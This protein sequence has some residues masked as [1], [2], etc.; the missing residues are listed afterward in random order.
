MPADIPGNRPLIDELQSE[1]EER[2]VTVFVGA[3]ASAPIW[4]LWS[5]LRTTVA[6]HAVNAGLATE[7]D[8]SAWEVI[9]DPEISMQM[10]R[11]T[12]GVEGFVSVLRNI[13][14]RPQPD[15]GRT[16]TP[17]HELI[18]TRNL[19]A[20]VT[21]NYDPGLLDAKL[22]L[23]QDVN[24]TG[25]TNSAD[26][27]ALSLW[28]SGDIYEEDSLP[29]LHLHGAVDRPSTI[30]IS[31]DDYRALYSRPIVQSLLEKLWQQERLLFLGYSFA[32]SR[33]VAIA[34]AVQ[35]RIAGSG[36]A[37][38]HFALVSL[39]PGMEYS[40]DLRRA[41][42]RLGGIRPIFYRERPEDEDPH[43]GLDELLRRLPES[44][45]PLSQRATIR[46]TRRTVRSSGPPSLLLVHD[47]TDDE[48]FVSR[49]LDEER[50]TR[51]SSDEV[52]AIAVTGLGGIGKTALV[53]SWLKSSPEALNTF[54]HAVFWSF[55][56]D[57]SP[58]SL[59]E[60]LIQ[61][62]MDQLAYRPNDALELSSQAADLVRQSRLLVILDGL[63][64]VQEAKSSDRF[65]SMTHQSLRQLLTAFPDS[66]GSLVVATSRFP[67][68]DL[69]SEIGRRA[70]WLPLNRLTNA[71]GSELLRRLGVDS[72]DQEIQNAVEV[73]EG[74]PL[75]LRILANA[76]IVSRSLPRAIGSLDASSD[77]LEGKLIRLVRFY[78]QI[79]PVEERAV[80]E[81]IALFRS[82]VPA[83][84]LAALWSSSHSDPHR[85]VDVQRF[86]E[87]IRALV[88]NGL[89][90]E[91]RVAGGDPEFACHPALREACRFTILRDD[92]SLVGSAIELLTGR[93]AGASYL[94]SEFGRL[95]DAVVLCL[96]VGEPLRALNLVATRLAGGEDFVRRPALSEAT[97]ILSL[98]IAE[99][100]WD[101]FLGVASGA[102]LEELASLVTFTAEAA[103]ISGNVSLLS[104]ALPSRFEEVEDLIFDLD[105]DLD[106][107]VRDQ[108]YVTML[109]QL[110]DRGSLA[111]AFALRDRLFDSQWSASWL[112]HLLSLLGEYE[113][114]T[115]MFDVARR[116]WTV[117][118]V[119][120]SGELGVLAG[121]EANWWCEHLLATGRPE[122][123]VRAA[124]INERACRNESQATWA[125]SLWVLGLSRFIA[126]DVAAGRESIEASMEA[127]Q[128]TGQLM[129]YLEGQLVLA[130]CDLVA[131][132]LNE[133]VRPLDEV[134][135]GAS[136]RDWRLLQ[137]DGLDLRGELRSA[138]G[139]TASAE[140][141]RAQSD[142]L[143]ERFGYKRRPY[144]SGWW[145]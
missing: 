13:F 89:C 17:R 49:P 90:T 143:A 113:R 54:E 91:Q 60:Y 23:R 85:M 73:L 35:R 40:P 18:V 43:G 129:T 36:A 141:D 145:R 80:L 112:G 41:Y 93:P 142:A 31:Q 118:D 114:A 4:P 79:M 12:L 8:T 120:E 127:A 135:A 105:W 109:Q 106:D 131:G 139:Q 52:R 128:S 20:A 22:R 65:G 88:R 6:R 134:I 136:V 110:I 76:A 11:E 21:T 132:E 56:S 9:G 125:A 30:V 116:H 115:E 28:V 122:V 74:H 99:G 37:L 71:Q 19:K 83:S 42:E 69:D 59:F 53:S 124:T 137:I 50:L 15:S 66:D 68:V 51:W 82:P 78:A 107:V 2:R 26:A 123:A 46:G 103:R 64:V 133:A 86:T 7:A 94:D 70:R 1:M 84:T 58:Q 24:G 44:A 97:E 81:T 48:F 25:Y 102:R 39:G 96:Q 63:E 144:R 119:L 32:D 130:F 47:G 62:G 92:P 138:L 5:D 77:G 33:I 126:G 87:A 108:A 121:F 104:S 101:Q 72:R 34:D 95:C 3:G 10:A 100:N 14:K 45:T 111:K 75:G 140:D 61:L 57:P 117:S 38:R 98:V 67:L 55:Y 16:W 29:V 27:D